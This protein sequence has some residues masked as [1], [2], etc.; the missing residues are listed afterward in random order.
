MNLYSS[1]SGS[2]AIRLIAAVPSGGETAYT[3]PAGLKNDI[4]NQLEPKLIYVELQALLQVADENVN[5]LNAEIKVPLGLGLRGL[6]PS[7]RKRVHRGDYKSGDASE[8]QRTFSNALRPE[9][10]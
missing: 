3:P 6:N 8:C 10:M 7:W 9:I 2:G 4:R 1:E 5:R